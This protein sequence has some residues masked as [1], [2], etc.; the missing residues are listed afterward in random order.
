MLLPPTVSHV[1]AD[2]SCTKTLSARS[3]L[4]LAFGTKKSQKAIRNLTANAIK[5]SPSKSKTEGL[6]DG[7]SQ[8]DPLA[9]AV[10]SS[11][12]DLTSSMRTR[13]EM[14]AEVDEGKPR[15]KPNMQ[16]STPAEVYPVE[17]LVG[18]ASILP[19]MGVKDWIEKINNGKDVQL[20]SRFIA[21]KLRN[22][23][24]SGDV[25]KLKIMRYLLLLVEWFLA[26]KPGSKP[27]KKVPRAEEMGPLNDA[28]GS[29]I[30]AGVTKRFADGFQLNKWHLD[31]LMTHILALALILD[32]FTIDTHDIREDLK[33]ENRDITKYF[34]ELGCSTAG[35]TDAERTA[36]GITKA[37]SQNHRIAR[38]RLPLAFPKMRVPMSG[39]RKR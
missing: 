36:L 7:R 1:I 28:Y 5:A 6:A 32:N 4:G 24:Q 31:N 26:L 3:N 15:P 12:A 2:Q 17:Q 14:Q 10:V 35:P 33:L 11:M 27:A 38:L 9:S 37:E 20:K 16:A 39:K 19:A 21:R 29:E 8:L 30:V 25:K 23:V 22:T 13:E 18:G 34:A